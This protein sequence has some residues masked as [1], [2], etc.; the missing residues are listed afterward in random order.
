MILVDTSVWVD[1]LRVGDPILASLLDAD[2]ILGH[3]WVVAEIALGSLKSRATV[4]DLLDGLPQAPAA[5]IEE[6]RHV[7][8]E[9]ALFSRGIGLVDV[10][11]LASCLLIPGSRLWTRDKRLAAVADELTLA[12]APTN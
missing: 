9:R 8:E 11:L 12:F 2:R 10:G 7:I 5:S 6:L 4:L 3:P 1:H